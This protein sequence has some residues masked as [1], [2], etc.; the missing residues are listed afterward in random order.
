MRSDI[1]DCPARRDARSF[2]RRSRSASA[3]QPT[4]ALEARLDG[5]PLR[6]Q[7][8]EFSIETSHKSIT[9]TNN[10]LL[11]AKALIRLRNTD[12]ERHRLPYT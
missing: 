5:R 3:A 11:R 6:L 2:N 10:R 4:G 1:G 7:P 9:A 12:A 8:L